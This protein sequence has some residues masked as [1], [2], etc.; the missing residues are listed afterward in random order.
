MTIKLENH[1]I[2]IS[3]Q[4]AK[5]MLN[6]NVCLIQSNN[7]TKSLELQIGEKEILL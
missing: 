3:F 5:I 6:K 2:Q 7:T 4:T 1:I